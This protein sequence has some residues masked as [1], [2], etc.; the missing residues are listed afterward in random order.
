MNPPK[1]PLA[2]DNPLWDFALA[3][4]AQESVSELL[5]ILQDQ[6]EQQVNR[7]LTCCWLTSRGKLWQGPAQVLQQG[8]L[9][10]SIEQLRAVRRQVREHKAQPAWQPYYQALLQAE[11]AGE[12]LE[13]AHW[14]W[15][16]SE[17]SQSV[18]DV[19]LEQNLRALGCFDRAAQP[20]FESL[21]SNLGNFEA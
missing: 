9:N 6:H 14:Y 7:L 16:A 2:L 1:A 17:Q 20:L 8:W 5:L 3:F 21:A 10:A 18:A 11:L 13:L 15:Q 19:T 4:Y 12:Q